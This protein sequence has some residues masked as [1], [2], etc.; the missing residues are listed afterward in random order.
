[1]YY[2]QAK[3]RSN[4]KKFSKTITSFQDDDFENISNYIHDTDS[5]I[6]PKPYIFT[7]IPL[8]NGQIITQ[9]IKCGDSEITC[10]PTKLYDYLIA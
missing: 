3:A 9:A 2:I 5:Y 8:S 4:S 1:M 7:H 10:S 6:L